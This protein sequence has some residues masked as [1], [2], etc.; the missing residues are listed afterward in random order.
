M[1]DVWE[2]NI[3]DVVFLDVVTIGVGLDEAPLVDHEA[4]VAVKELHVGVSELDRLSHFRLVALI[5]PRGEQRPPAF[6]THKT[7]FQLQV[8][9]IFFAIH[10]YLL[11]DHTDGQ[12]D[13]GRLG[14]QG[15]QLDNWNK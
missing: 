2:V 4:H 5:V 15:F 1:L 7:L 8:T 14:I 3:G 9:V 10:H 11:A 13:A 12:V 6:I